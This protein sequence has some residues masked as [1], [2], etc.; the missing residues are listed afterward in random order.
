MESKG[1]LNPGAAGVVFD[2]FDLGLPDL[3]SHVWVVRWDITRGEIS[4]QRVLTYPTLNVVFMT[5]GA[6]LHGPEQRVITRDLRETGWA[7]GVMLEPAATPLLSTS[8]PSTLVS[9]TEPLHEAP[10]DNITR[11]MASDY[12]RDEI[13]VILRAWLK[14]HADGVNERGRLMNKGWHTV[15][16]RSDITSVEELSNA[17]AVSKRSLERLVKDHTGV[18]PKWLIECR[19]MQHAAIRLFEHPDTDLNMLAAELGFADQAHFSRRYSK[20]I[21]ETP[22]TTRQA[23]RKRMRN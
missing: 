1:H 7:V 6:V 5:F 11:S 2:R 23:A 20:I 22:D 14:P 12:N 3:V 15:Q 4:S 17:L 10:S 16:D 19:R 8:N 9:S 21:G 13:D 18:T